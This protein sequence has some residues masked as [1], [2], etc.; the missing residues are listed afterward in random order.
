MTDY[1]NYGFILFVLLGYSMLDT[2]RDTHKDPVAQQMEACRSSCDG[3]MRNYDAEKKQCN[4]EER[5]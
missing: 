2:C 5:F 1:L 3:K 4:C